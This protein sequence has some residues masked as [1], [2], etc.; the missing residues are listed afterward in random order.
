MTKCARRLGRSR[1]AASLQT[2]PG[3]N[4]KVKVHVFA[5]VFKSV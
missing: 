1:I 2:L 4:K 5:R 3:Q